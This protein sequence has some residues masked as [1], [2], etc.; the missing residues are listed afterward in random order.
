MH[1]RPEC[2]YQSAVIAEKMHWEEMSSKQMQVVFRVS[3]RKSD[4]TSVKS[5]CLGLVSDEQARD[6]LRLLPHNGLF[7][8]QTAYKFRS[9]CDFQVLPIREHTPLPS[10][11]GQVYEDLVPRL[12]PTSFHTAFSWWRHAEPNDEPVPQFLPP[13]VYSR[14][15]SGVPSKLLM[16]EVERADTSALPSVPGQS[17]SRVD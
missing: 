8:V 5:Q 17:E 3:R 2:A 13:F 16:Q 14:Y 4:P 7:E 9:L 15:S 10:V 1:Y 6:F 11:E 12:V